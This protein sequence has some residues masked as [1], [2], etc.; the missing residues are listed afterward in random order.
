MRVFLRRCETHQSPGHRHSPAVRLHSI[1]CHPDGE[2]IWQDVCPQTEKARYS[3][4]TYPLFPAL[5][6][7]LR[8]S[9]SHFLAASVCHLSASIYLSVS[10]VVQ[11]VSA[12]VNHPNKNPGIWQSVSGNILLLTNDSSLFFP[13]SISFLSQFCLVSRQTFISFLYICFHLVIS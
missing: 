10:G 3:V 6:Q 5:S 11:Q 13:H 4:C 7:F 8:L 2:L 12:L 1:I 9:D